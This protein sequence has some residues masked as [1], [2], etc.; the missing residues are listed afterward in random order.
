EETLKSVELDYKKKLDFVNRENIKLNEEIEELSNQ[1]EEYKKQLD[2]QTREN[3]GLEKSKNQLNLIQH[4]KKALEAK[5]Q[6]LEREN[7]ES[8]NIINELTIEIN[9]LK[10]VLQ[11]YQDEFVNE[12][13]FI[14]INNNNNNNNNSSSKNISLNSNSNNNVLNNKINSIP[15]HHTQPTVRFDKLPNYET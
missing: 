2:I 8:Q 5:I 4:Q 11:K 15:H 10:N 3:F 14:T 7:N 6:R 13:N 12:N 9:E 1:V